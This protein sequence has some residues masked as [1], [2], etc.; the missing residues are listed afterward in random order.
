MTAPKTPTPS[1]ISRLLASAGFERATL[2]PPTGVRWDGR[3]D[4]RTRKRQAG[5]E[6]RAEGCDVSV[7]WRPG[8][9]VGNLDRMCEER[10]AQL[11]CY[12]NILQVAATA[13]GLKAMAPA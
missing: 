11:S 9:G 4:S 5:F 3:P 8:P 2:R 12:T 13:P 7:I 10:I 6:V 1:G